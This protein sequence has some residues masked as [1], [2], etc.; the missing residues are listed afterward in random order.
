MNNTAPQSFSQL[1][2]D[3]QSRFIGF[4]SHYVRDTAVA[5]DIV[6]DAFIYYWTNR[7]RLPD[8]TNVPAYILATVKNRCLD[9][10]RHIRVKQNAFARILNNAQ[11]ELDMRITSLQALEPTEIYTKEIYELVNKALLKL[12]SKTQRIFHKSRVNQLPNK[13]I[14]ET[15]NIS[16]KTV[17]A[18]ITAALKLLRAEL[19]DYFPLL[20]ILFQ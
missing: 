11:W 20:F 3:Y 13:E 1:F 16:V 15:M 8:D 2:V 10:L 4:A 9:H 5:E 12:P 7:S 17:E 19:G 6:S 14:A 18:H